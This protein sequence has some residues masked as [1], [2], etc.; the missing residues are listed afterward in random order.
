MTPTCPFRRILSEHASAHDACGAAASFP[1]AFPVAPGHTLVV[2]T[3]H[4]TD[5]FELSAD[6]QQ[7]VWQR[8][9]EVRRR[10]AQEFAP[11]GYNVGLNARSAAG[12]TVPQAHVHV[13][14]RY[15]GD[16]S[17]PRGGVRWVIPGRAAWWEDDE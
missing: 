8:V 9:S 3:R 1:D 2:P 7:G 13:I 6:E 14:P 15:D 11:A 4:V 10:L 5:F 12:Q 17:D 16:V